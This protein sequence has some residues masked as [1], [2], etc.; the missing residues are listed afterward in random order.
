MSEQIFVETT[1]AT[2][3][4]KK[5]FEI[6]E[7]KG[8]GHPD[9]ICDLVMD[10]VSIELS[11]LY[12][13]ETGIIQHHNL[14]KTMLV[15]GQTENR[16]GGGS[17]LKP[18]KLI[19]GDR[20]TILSD[21]HR[22]PIGDFMITTAKSWFEN[23]LRN[24]NEHVEFALEIGQS[25]K[26][27]RSIFEGSKTVASN[28]TSALVGYAPFT[29][30]ESVVLET[31][32]YINSKKFKDEFPFAGE[33]VKI[34]GFR[35]GQWLDL[36]VA[37]AF[38][39]RYVD[40]VDDYFAKKH[41]ILEA[42]IEHAS[43]KT[44]LNIHGAINCL[45]DKGRGIDGTYLTV[46]GTS[47]DNADS[48]EVGRGNK[49]NQVIS[50]SRPAGAEAIAGKNPVSHIG[51]IYNTLSFKL[52]NDIQQ[53]VPDIEEV[54]VWM[55]NIIGRPVNDPK[56]VVVQPL[57]KNNSELDTSEQAQIRE[58]ISSGLEKMDQFCRKLL[59][60]ETPIA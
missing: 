23:N 19:M 41:R 52:A 10:K 24:V 47:A 16:F 3:T 58:I 42:I 13:K 37:V 31:E 17:V 27:L 50:I 55:Y 14:D 2:P 21:D 49:A 35:N 46:L 11:K 60:D 57:T 7:R 59:Y 6:V 32:R 4:F 28:D 20:V 25:S 18:M 53:Q 43:E 54:F 38:V 33:D 15:A 29:K 56:A 22:V 44:D 1:K 30:T 34:M 5:Q 39:D 40:S 26:E 12:L 8:I 36:T 9:T 45:D 48:G 51:K